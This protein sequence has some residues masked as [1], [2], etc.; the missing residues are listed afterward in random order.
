MSHLGRVLTFVWLIAVLIFQSSYTASLSSIL[1]AQQSVAT[2]A[3][4]VDLQKSHLT[5]GY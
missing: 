2:I 4:F 5:V 1:A 3:N